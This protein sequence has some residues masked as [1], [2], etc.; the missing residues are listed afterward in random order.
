MSRPGFDVK[1]NRQEAGLTQIELAD[2]IGVSRRTIQSLE[3]GRS[4]HPR[5]LRKVADH[6]GI[7][8]ADLRPEAVA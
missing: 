3:S 7:R 6:Y 8:V 5:S 1:K 2:Q 4:A